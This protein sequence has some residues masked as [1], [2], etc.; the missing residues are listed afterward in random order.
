MKLYAITYSTNEG[1]GS[2]S[3]KDRAGHDTWLSE[4]CACQVLKEI[5]NDEVESQK[6]N[7]VESECYTTNCRIVYGDDTWAEYR[8]IQFT[9]PSLYEMEIEQSIQDC[10][11]NKLS[12]KD[13]AKV[14]G[15]I[16]N[17]Y[18]HDEA[19]L[20]IDNYAFVINDKLN[21]GMSVNDICSQNK[22]DFLIEVGNYTN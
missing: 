10:I 19:C 14:R 1:V 20:P 3:I 2:Y 4:E 17:A 9:T 6:N 13:L 15:F 22:W 18:L 21:N 12:A 7:I 11:E 16:E 8:V 5:Y